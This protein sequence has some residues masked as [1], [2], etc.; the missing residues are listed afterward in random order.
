MSSSHSSIDFEIA[1]QQGKAAGRLRHV[2][3]AVGRR[4]EDAVLVAAVVATTQGLGLVGI[5]EEA[6]AVDDVVGGG[7]QHH[8]FE[9]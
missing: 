3:F 7:G 8:A 6:K 9:G 5:T 1:A 4:A 2:D